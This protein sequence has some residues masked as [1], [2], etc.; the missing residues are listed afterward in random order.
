ME[1][2][3]SANSQPKTFCDHCGLP[4]N[5]ELQKS[6]DEYDQK[7][8]CCHGCQSVYSIIHDLGLEQFYT[9]RDRTA[10]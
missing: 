6:I 5:I 7:R 10:D 9:L 1:L 4:L 3:S 2:V 8:F